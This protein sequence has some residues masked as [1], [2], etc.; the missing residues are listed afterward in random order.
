MVRSFLEQADS[1]LD[2]RVESNQIPLKSSG[3]SGVLGSPEMADKSGNGKP[4]SPVF[5]KVL[6]HGAFARQ[7]RR[8]PAFH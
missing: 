1:Y 8:R 5:V 6:K 3:F 2:R 7:S 4:E